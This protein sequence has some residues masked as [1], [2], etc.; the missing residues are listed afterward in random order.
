MSA[1]KKTKVIQLCLI[2]LFLTLVA[3]GAAQKQPPKKSVSERFAEKVEPQSLYPNELYITATGSGDTQ[4]K[5]N[6]NAINGVAQVIKV[7][8][9]SQQQLVEKY[10]ETGA[11][12]DMLLEAASTFTSQIELV[13]EQSLKN[14]NI[15]KT[16]LSQEDGRYYAFAYMDRAETA[17]IYSKDIANIDNEI[18]IY[19]GKFGSATDKLTKLAYLHKAL[20]LSAQ[21]EAMNEQLTTIT[22]GARSIPPAVKPT[23]LISARFELT[24]QIKVKFEL[25]YEK[26]DEFAVAVEDVLTSFGFQIVDADPDVLVSGKMTMERLERKGFFIRWFVELH[27]TDVAA[28]TEFLTYD[29]DD[30]E[31]HKSYAEAE[32]R[33]ASRL[34]K[35]IKKNLY[36]K[37][38][39]YLN[40]LMAG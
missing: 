33:A 25:D 24:K 28:G 27:F 2:V 30:R 7:D 5:A 21:R 38:E 23:D 22:Q 37:F 29:D 26:W 39:D 16:W 4:D 17:E 40:S 12:K 13:T 31:G 10:F 36:R 35:T 9:K 3:C 8:L 14:V 15:G 19:Y 1:N 34:S 11:G 20:N 32:R 18:S 6:K